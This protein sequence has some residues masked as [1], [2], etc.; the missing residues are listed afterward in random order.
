M[1]LLCLQSNCAKG[2]RKAD[3]SKGVLP[4][5]VVQDVSL[6]VP[7]PFALMCSRIPLRVVHKD[8]GTVIR[9]VPTEVGHNI[10][11]DLVCFHGALD[12][13]IESRA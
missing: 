8:Q 12:T 9:V 11:H 13:V 4:K 7:Y 6:I 5:R 1:G 2:H 3:Q 10:S